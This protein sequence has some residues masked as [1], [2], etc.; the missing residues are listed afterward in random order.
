MQPVDLVM[1]VVTRGRGSEAVRLAKQAGAGGGTIFL[2]TGTIQSKLLDFLELTDIRKEIVFTAVAR[3]K[4]DAVLSALDKGLA[5]KRPGHGIAVSIP[6]RG[7]LGAGHHIDL[8][9]VRQVDEAQHQAIFTV[10]DMGMASDV[11]EAAKRAGARGGTIIHARGSGIHDT[12]MLF[13]MP[14]EPEKEIVMTIVKTEAAEGVV[15]AIR[16]ALHIDEP[17]KGVMFVI[18][19]SQAIGLY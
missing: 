9:E 17:G 3:E 1:L 5:L 7:F 4:R 12:E 13:M 10:V 14:I 19:V 8:R 15:R 6:L 11:V 2:G 16:D 18:D